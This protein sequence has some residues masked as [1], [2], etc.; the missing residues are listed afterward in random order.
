MIKVFNYLTRKTEA[1]KPLRGRVIRM[2]ACGPTVYN[3]QHIG[4]YRTYIF[5]DVLRRALSAAG[6]RVRHIINI[7]DVG[8][9]T[10]DADTGE[11]KLAAAARRERKTAWEI[12]R[13]YE[14]RFKEDIRKLNILEP[15]KW[16]RATEHIEEQIA[17]VRTLE[18]KGFTYIIARDGVYFDTGKLPDYG[19]LMPSRL[20]GLRAGAR[21]ARAGGKRNATDFA[22]W[23]FSPEG[24]RRDMEWESP[25]GKGFPGWHIECSAMSMKYLGKTFELHAGGVDHIPIHHTNEIA[26]SEAATGRPFVR[27]VVEGEH[28]LAQGKKMSKSLGNFYT[29]GD[30]EE[31]GF[32]PLD[33]RYL[34]LQA[35]YRSLLNFTWQSLAAAREGLA[36]ITN[37]LDLLRAQRRKKAPRNTARLAALIAT[38]E[39]AFQKAVANDLDTPAALSVLNRLLHESGKL[40]QEDRLSGQG[41][42]ELLET[43]LRFD[44]VLGLDLAHRSALAPRAAAVA[45]LLDERETLR[46][47]RKFSEADAVRG[48]I[49]AMGYTV[50]D[51]P[52]GPRV[53]QR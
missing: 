30:I 10:S 22:L 26:Q 14:E 13:F 18:K 27:Y 32:H 19:K 49:E 24:A 3:H 20:K 52:E 50:E 9:L 39:R 6:Y 40:R 16:V 46:K 34:V 31:R 15:V 21:V 38:H 44:R 4:N 33:F 1:L 28:L 45:K 42:K 37:Q 11:D 51:T 8:H 35:H 17:L 48:K 7:T 29:L 43:V 41:A 5:E 53:K 12:A 25:W 47:E 36:G 23:K 2:Y